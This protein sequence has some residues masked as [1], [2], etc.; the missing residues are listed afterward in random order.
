MLYVQQLKLDVPV[1]IN[2]Q[3]LKQHFKLL[4]VLKLMKE[5]HALDYYQVQIF[6]TSI[7]LNFH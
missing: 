1:F 7:L 6:V 2:D 5:E 4:K 3:Q